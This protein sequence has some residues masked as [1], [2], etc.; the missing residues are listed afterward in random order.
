MRI[1]I[2]FDTDA[3]ELCDSSEFNENKKLVIK[4]TANVH[5]IKDLIIELVNMICDGKDHPHIVID[6][7]D[8]GQVVEIEEY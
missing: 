3:I 6:S 4:L 1:R 8:E 5:A 2:N 7:I